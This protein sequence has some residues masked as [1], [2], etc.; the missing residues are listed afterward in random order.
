MDHAVA[1]EPVVAA[2][3]VETPV[4]A[5]AQVDAVEIARD[6]ADHLEVVGGDLVADGREDP[7]QVGVVLPVLLDGDRGRLL[8]RGHR[9]PPSDVRSTRTSPT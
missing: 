1:V 2:R 6:L 5:V 4:R 9:R 3:R 8:E 7:E